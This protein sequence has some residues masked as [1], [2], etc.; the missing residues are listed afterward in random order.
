MKRLLVLVFALGLVLGAGTI[1]PALAALLSCGAPGTASTVCT[2]SVSL[3]VGPPTAPITI[4]VP[5]PVRV[6]AQGRGIVGP[7]FRVN[8]PASLGGGFFQINS[9]TLDPDPGIFFSVS[10]T[11][12]T[13]FPSFVTMVFAEP[14]LLTGTVSDRKSV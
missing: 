10:E 12:L 5:V 1:T 13:P 4:S 3:R 14:I 11:N 8:I 7:N 9:A 6:D 2:G